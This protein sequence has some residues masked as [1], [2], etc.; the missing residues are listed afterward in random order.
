MDSRVV[1]RFESTLRDYQRDGFYW[2][3]F[4]NMQMEPTDDMGLGKT[5][6]ALCILEHQSLVVAP[7]SVLHNWI[8]ETKKFRPNLSIC[9]Y[10]GTGRVFDKTADIILTSYAILRN[11]IE[12]LQSIPWQVVVLDEA[13]AIKNPKSLTAQAAFKIQ[14]KFRLTL[15]GTPVEIRLTELWSHIH[16]LCP[17]LLGHNDFI[18]H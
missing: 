16:F 7:T 2:L 4:L 8:S 5:V 15:S 6:Q 11:D 12:H 17:G 10:H 14:A 1:P 13:Q 18:R 9:L 3:S